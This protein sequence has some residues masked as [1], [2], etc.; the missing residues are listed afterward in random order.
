LSLIAQGWRW[1]RASEKIKEQ[2]PYCYGDFEISLP[3]YGK[4]AN[5]WKRLVFS[6][7]E[8]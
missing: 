5:R 8:Q 1:F 6:T 2:F 7:D 4:P 3:D